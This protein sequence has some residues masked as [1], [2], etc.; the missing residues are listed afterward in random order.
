VWRGRHEA[1]EPTVDDD[2]TRTGFVGSL[3]D[4]DEGLLL[5]R[6]PQGRNAPTLIADHL[7][8]LGAAGARH[9]R[10]E[11]GAASGLDVDLL[12]VLGREQSRVNARGGVLSV[13]GLRLGVT[14][15]ATA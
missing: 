4:G 12:P 11:A 1:K 3:L 6:G 9:I 7:R 15:G 13:R 2:G 10:V 8:A 5:L 14:A